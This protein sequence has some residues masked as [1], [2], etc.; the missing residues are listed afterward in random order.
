MN[1]TGL[2]RSAW[3]TAGWVDTAVAGLTG[4]VCG[5]WAA[6]S[7]AGRRENEGQPDQTGE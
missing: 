2:V 3:L 7:G 1:M 6:D 4:G 5:G